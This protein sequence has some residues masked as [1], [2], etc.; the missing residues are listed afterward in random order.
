MGRTFNGELVT[1]DELFADLTG[2]AYKKYTYFLDDE[3]RSAPQPNQSEINPILIRYA[4][5]LLT[6]AEAENELNG[7]TARAYGAINQVRERES[8]DMPNVTPGLSQDEFRQVV[9]RERRVEFAGEG[10]YYQDIIRWRTAEVVMNA[11]GLDQNENVIE[12]RNFDPSKDYLW[13]LPD[14]DILLNTNL[15]QNPGY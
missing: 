14:R 3:I 10:L 12:R 13:P 15:E 6:V 5:M 2:Y 4:E 1:G 7:P 11:N 8:V 9:R